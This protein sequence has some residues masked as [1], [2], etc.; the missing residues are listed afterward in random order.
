MFAR[1]GYTAA[2][3]AERHEKKAIE[4]ALKSGSPRKL[5]LMSRPSAPPVS[6]EEL[7]SEYLEIVSH[8]DFE[9]AEYHKRA[10]KAHDLLAKVTK[11]NLTMLQSSVLTFSEMD[12]EATI[13]ISLLAGAIRGR[14]FSQI[15]LLLAL[16][17]SV[18]QQ[19]YLL[20]K[21][22]FADNKERIDV[23]HPCA[24]MSVPYDSTPEL[25]LREIENRYKT[26]SKA[27]F[28]VKALE[29]DGYHTLDE[30]SLVRYI[31][32]HIVFKA[33]RYLLLIDNPAGGT[34]RREYED[35]AI[36]LL[37]NLQETISRVEH[38]NYELV[39]RPFKCLLAACIVRGNT[40]IA[41][42]LI[43]MWGNLNFETGVDLTSWAVLKNPDKMLP[44]MAKAPCGFR[45][46]RYDTNGHLEAAAHLGHSD[47]VLDALVE[48]GATYTEELAEAVIALPGV[49][50]KRVGKAVERYKAKLKT[51]ARRRDAL[52]VGLAAAD[53]V[54]ASAEA[55]AS[56]GH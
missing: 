56:M 30:T 6:D 32:Y 1:T 17:G 19:D 38:F 18:S 3:M 11:Q 47:K 16:N 43:A 27:A 44:L 20:A 14:D 54:T 15:L 23:V 41:E 40:R 29:G 26:Q 33:L 4:E 24:W 31:R 36:K 28:L 10:K 46:V 9:V 8:Y 53:V 34:T 48:G 2:E 5:Y 13:G 22:D 21:R 42:Q 45:P 7:L 37:L 39:R 35:K 12:M 49:S 51:F 55:G 50:E 52:L 25:I